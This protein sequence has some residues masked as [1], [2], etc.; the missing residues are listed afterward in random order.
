M[1][2]GQRIISSEV[3][4]EGF[5]DEMV[6]LANRVLAGESLAINEISDQ[7]FHS[8]E[9]LAEIAPY[10]DRVRLGTLAFAQ[11]ML[12]QWIEKPAG[13]LRR[14]P[15]QVEVLQPLAIGI[16]GLLKRGL[17][18][19]LVQQEEELVELGAKFYDAYQQLPEPASR[20]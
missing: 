3:E 2:E 16:A 15:H 14:L 13:H 20:D 4:A 11:L 17:T 1:V 7:L 8:D 9:L 5:I 18:G 12:D 10:V 19:Q 6:M